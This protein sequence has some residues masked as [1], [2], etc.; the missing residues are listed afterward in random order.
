MSINQQDEP[1][2]NAVG[3]RIVKSHGTMEGVYING[4]SQKIKMHTVNHVG[5]LS[6]FLRNTS[7][8]DNY[9]KR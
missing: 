5:A 6:F 9:T 7:I 8:G 1:T 3:E 4:K 2:Y